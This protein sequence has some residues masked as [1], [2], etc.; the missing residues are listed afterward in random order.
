[1]REIIALVV[2][3]VPVSLLAFGGG[4]AIIAPVHE[5]V[6]ERHG[7][8]T[9]REFVDIFAMSR[10]SPGPGAMM[11]TLIGW[12]VAGWAGAIAA[13]IAIFLPSSLLCYSVAR[14]WNRYRGTPLHSALEQGLLPIGIGLSLSGA[15]TIM[16]TSDTGLLGWSIA[17]LATALLVWRNLH[18]LAVLAGGGTAYMLV[19]MLLR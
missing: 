13:T 19:S 10:A 4:A 7:W 17:I 15:L 18:P 9:T 12:K 2:M 3:L 16:R 5:G 11:V 8:L 6:V 14:A 1:M